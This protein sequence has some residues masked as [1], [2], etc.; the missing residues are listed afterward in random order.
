MT[1]LFLTFEGP[2]GAG[3]ST[4]IRLLAD[5]LAA[6]GL[7]VVATREPGGTE[8]GERIRAILLDRTS[9]GMSATTETLLHS[10]ARAQ[11]IAEIIAPA[12][13]RGEIVLCDRFVESTLA[14][15]GGGRGLAISDLRRI[16]D[17]ATGGV[18][19]D[20]RILLDIDVER[21]LR[22]RHG[23]AES[24]NRMDD[25]G[26]AFHR[27]VRDAYL[28]LVKDNPSGWVVINADR[29]QAD[30]AKDVWSA[31]ANAMAMT[32]IETPVVVGMHS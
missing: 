13:D 17:F 3:K 6:R 26:L 21:G 20:V 7:T 29:P 25:E 16:Q 8:I 15:Q 12:L 19:P 32:G 14:Y 4:Q 1:G 27:R 28:E 9:I 5:E 31:V 24:T 30:V 22:R 10:A 23:E 11:H 18:Q 2:E